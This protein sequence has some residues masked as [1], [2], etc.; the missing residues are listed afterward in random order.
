MSAPMRGVPYL[1][2]VWSQTSSGRSTPLPSV[3]RSAMSPGLFSRIFCASGTSRLSAWKRATHLSA[4]STAW[5]AKLTSPISGAWPRQS[6]WLAAVPK[7][8]SSRA[9]I[10]YVR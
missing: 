6:T 3:Q 1:A 8:R 4:A 10:A 7:L 2:T 9:R 5:S